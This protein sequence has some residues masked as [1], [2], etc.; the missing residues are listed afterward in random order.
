MVTWLFLGW[1]VITLPLTYLG[2]MVG[3]K[4]ETIERPVQVTKIFRDIP[5]QPWYLSQ[6]HCMPAFGLVTFGCIFAEFQFIMDSEWH[7]YIGVMFGLLLVNYVLVV[8]IVSV[9]SVVQTY[10]MLRAGDYNWWW[11]SFLSGGTG[12]VFMMAYSLY[13]M[14]AVLEMDVLAGELIYLLYMTAV[15]TCFSV[16]CGA[17]SLLSSWVFVNTIYHT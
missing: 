8:A 15:S 13:Y 17:V 6:W 12:G 9:L 11:R 10:F 3:Y 16:I 5:E 1:C 2:A 14:I 7:G 4:M